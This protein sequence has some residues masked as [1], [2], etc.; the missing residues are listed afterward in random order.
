MTCEEKIKLLNPW[1]EAIIEKVKKELKQD[2]LS[3]D[4]AFVKEYLSGK[5]PLRAST[6]E[7]TE[8][9]FQAVSS[10]REDVWERVTTQWILK[11]GDIYA[12]FAERL[13]KI[14]PR[15][16]QIEE[17]TEEQA[18]FLLNEAY[19][20]FDAVAVYI[21]AVMNCVAFSKERFAQMQNLA[22]QKSKKAEEEKVHAEEQLEREALLRRHTLELQRLSDKYEKKLSGM[23]KK[24]VQDTEALKKQLS[25]LQRK[26]EAKSAT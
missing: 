26:L 19:E 25:I 6:E 12:F 22:R 10:G 5:H 17:L 21:F 18:S 14:N 24:Y 8:A 20:K 23:Q 4:R 7:L 3:F 15:F 16:D 11:H 2:H 9:Y 13:E 1:K